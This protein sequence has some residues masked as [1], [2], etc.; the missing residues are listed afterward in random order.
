VHKEIIKNSNIIIV[1][2]N[3]SLL[4]VEKYVTVGIH[5]INK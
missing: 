2:A 5:M 1:L 4:T 3:L